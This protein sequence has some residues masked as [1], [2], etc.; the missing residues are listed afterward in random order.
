MHVPPLCGN[1]CHVFIARV[2]VC[3]CVCV[4]SVE[5][6]EDKHESLNKANK[7]LRDAK[8]EVVCK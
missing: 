3:V 8:A 2:C 7:E 5:R 4:S 6:L 1:V